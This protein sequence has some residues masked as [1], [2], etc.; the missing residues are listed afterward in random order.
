MGSRWL[1]WLEHESNY[2][3]VR[4]SNPTSAIL[5]PLSRLGRPGSIPALVPLSC[6]MAARHRNYE[7]IKETTHKVAENSPTAHDRFHPSW[8][9][10]GR[11]SPRVSVNLML[12]CAYLMSPKK[13]E[14]GRGL[15]KSF[16]QTS[17]M[18]TPR[19]DLNLDQLEIAIRLNRADIARTKIFLE[20]KRWKK[21]ALDDFMFTVI[22]NDQ[23]DFVSLLLENGFNLEHF[24][25]VHTLERLYTESLKKTDY[26]TELFQLMWKRARIYKMEWVMLRDVGRIIKTIMGDFY[27][28]LY[29]TRRFR[30][31]VTQGG[32]FDS[33]EEDEEVGSNQGE[34][35]LSSNAT[36]ASTL[37]E[38]EAGDEL[39]LTLKKSR[40]SKSVTGDAPAD[41][42]SQVHGK[43]NENSNFSTQ[44]D[45]DNPKTK[46]A[47]KTR[48][49]ERSHA[50]E[51]SRPL[52]ERISLR[53]DSEDE[54]TLKGQ[55]DQSI[56]G[57]TET[58]VTDGLRTSPNHR[59]SSSLHSKQTERLPPVPNNGRRCIVRPI[60]AFQLGYQPYVGYGD[61]RQTNGLLI[62]G[63][64]V[65]TQPG[66]HRTLPLG[67]HRVIDG[68][69]Q[70]RLSNSQPPRAVAESISNL[71]VI[72]KLSKS[73]QTDKQTVVVVKVHSASTEARS[74]SHERRRSHAQFADP[75]PKRRSNSASPFTFTPRG[76]KGE[77]G[78][79]NVP[80][81]RKSVISG[82]RVAHSLLHPLT[83]P[84]KVQ[85]QL[86]EAERVAREQRREKER[87]RRH[88][89]AQGKFTLLERLTGK[90]KE[91]NFAHSATVY[92]ERPAREIMVM[93]ILLGKLTM[94]RLFWTYEKVWKSKLPIFH[95]SEP[96][97]AALTASILFGELANKCDDVTCKEEYEEAARTFE[98]KADEVLEECYQEDRV[99][100][101]LLLSRKLDFYGGTSV[102][103]LAARGRCIR[104]MAHPCC[105][106]L[107]SGVWMGE[108]SPKF[109]FIQFLSG[110]IVGLTF[111]LLLPQIT[112]YITDG[113]DG[114]SS[115]DQG[116]TGLK[117]KREHRSEYCEYSRTVS[118]VPSRKNAA[119]SR[120]SYQLKDEITF[121][122]QSLE[123]C[124]KRHIQ[125][126]FTYVPLISTALTISR[127]GVHHS[128]RLK[129]STFSRSVL[130]PVSKA[131][132]AIAESLTSVWYS[133]VFFGCLFILLCSPI[134][135][136]DSLGRKPTEI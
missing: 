14:S 11:H 51:D 133:S 47:Q 114:A 78:A 126:E 88:R 38:E 64:Y 15:S 25:S 10:S 41:G 71:K 50:K 12:Y 103:R 3:K 83:D 69:S 129:T 73:E 111:P 101:E 85:L 70:V 13:G 72:R 67:K 22:L 6:G 90:A 74:K 118:G 35:S 134:L 77:P 105:Q 112:K 61:A 94:A 32:A 19:D 98:E 60:T 59:H 31:T 9:S 81:R 117:L 116:S 44:L 40:L 37:P 36:S 39:H 1:K 121:M 28:P 54:A 125:L 42:F 75:S 97:A 57:S 89:V 120:I 84:E 24:L 122:Q 62:F 68:S 5:L 136:C 106:E 27:Q 95:A 58:L 56:G 26:K 113:N 2:Q 18:D 33:S 63:E 46:G 108:L 21:G 4:G 80:T 102:I 48:S 76:V 128:P 65:P 93:C 127:C 52:L 20:G 92:L 115:V 16:Q 82:R 29:L 104:F 23:N 7:S 124:Y 123:E 66:A 34:S 91:H 130:C 30:N 132:T 119:I 49:R 87:R 100:T 43:T 107:L 109:T 45:K 110:I 8:G 99:R 55:S 96:I 135:A 17:G 53:D 131:C 79:R 86:R